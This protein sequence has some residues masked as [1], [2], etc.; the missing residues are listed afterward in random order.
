MFT[1]EKDCALVW[2]EKY[3]D[4]SDNCTYIYYSRLRLNPSTQRLEHYITLRYCTSFLPYF[5]KTDTMKRIIQIARANDTLYQLKNA[6][7]VVYRGIELGDS[8]CY[9]SA[10]SVNPCNYDR[11]YYEGKDFGHDVIWSISLTLL[12]TLSLGGELEPDCLDIAGLSSAKSPSAS[13]WQPNIAQGQLTYI[14]KEGGTG[15]YTNSNDSILVLNFVQSSLGNQPSINSKMWQINHSQ[16]GYYNDW[17]TLRNEYKNYKYSKPITGNGFYP[18]LAAVPYIRNNTDWNRNRRI[19]NTQNTIL[20]RIAT[21]LEWFYRN[22]FEDD[23][24]VPFFGFINHKRKSMFSS[25]VLVDKYRNKFFPAILTHKRDNNLSYPA[26]TIKSDW[27]KAGDYE[28]LQLYGYGYSSPTVR[29]QIERK[30]DGRKLNMTVVQN[31]DTVFYRHKYNL[32]NGGDEEYRII[33]TKSSRTDKPFQ[34]LIIGDQPNLDDLN[35]DPDNRRFGRISVDDF[36][37]FIDLGSNRFVNEL[38]AINDL[39]LF[40]Y[41]YPADEK[42]YVTASQIKDGNSN[43]RLFIFNTSGFQLMTKTFKAGET[44]EI[45]TNNLAQGVYF[46]R[47]EIIDDDNFSIPSHYELKSFVIER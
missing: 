3:R 38:N 29:M 6:K 44:T 22:N 36:E 14:N 30:R 17:F 2:Q 31:A 16:M 39:N 18:H 20:P 23:I 41:P 1:K 28:K 24:A 9:P 32:I 33:W 19:F 26:D 13:L 4:S 34:E 43:I 46:I 7:P 35:A 15:F 25:F 8:C 47:A 12:D 11:V 40:I 10:T 21:S 37:Q 5:G 42:L 27:F 45:L